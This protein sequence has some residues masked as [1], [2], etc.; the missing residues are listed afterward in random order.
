LEDGGVERLFG[1]VEFERLC[2]PFLGDDIRNGRRPT[3]N[4]QKRHGRGRESRFTEAEAQYSR[5][6][7]RL[8]GHSD[9]AVNV[10]LTTTRMELALAELVLEEPKEV[11]EDIDF[12]IENGTPFLF[13]SVH[14]TPL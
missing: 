6:P 2:L 3:Y 12:V 1:S 7:V 11:E 8:S 5:E 13:L 4:N 10:A 14:T 9:I